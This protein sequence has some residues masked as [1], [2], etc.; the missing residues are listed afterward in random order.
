MEPM[1]A[2]D[3]LR[4][5]PA[6]DDLLR[7]PALLPLWRQLGPAGARRVIAAVLAELRAA[8]TPEKLAALE[9][10]LAAAA[11]RRREPSLRPVI[12]A[13]GV[14]LHTNLGRA[15]LSAAAAARLAEIASSY[16][17]L[18]LDLATGHRARRD[19]HLDALLAELTG[20]EASLV[21]NNNA[22]AVLLALHTLAVDLQ[23]EVL[24]SRGEL[25]EIGESFRIA[26]I[27]ARGGAR[28]VEVGATNRTRLADYQAALT[29]A[30]RL[31]LRVHRSNFVQAG[32]VEQ[33]ELAALA[34]FARQHG[35]P[36]VEDLGSGALAPLPGLSP[37]PT[38]AASLRAG[39]DLV[40]YSGDK[41]LGGPQAGLL[42]GRAPLIARLR[43]NPLFRALRVDKLILAALEAT[44]AAYARGDLDS[45][46]VFA[47]AAAPG[48]EARVRAFA[49]QLP[50]ALGA[51]VVAG[52]SLLGGGS[53]PG[54]TLPTWLIALPPDCAPRLRRAQPPVL[55]RL[56]RDRCLLDLRTVFACQEPA[57]RD[58]LTIEA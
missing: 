57:L 48:L 37:E 24:I 35:L 20:A 30:T 58:A 12:N 54:Q 56:E 41:L 11:H 2:H 15:P 8:P 47:L 25:V 10:T 31:I 53:T 7:R 6:V 55:A 23:G 3:L 28:L 13:T 51:E 4:Q 32:F 18:E 38:V 27:V 16:T 49:A 29:P 36:L 44:L 5:L 22:A 21:V 17:N 19:R 50:P 26:D 45:L 46:P 40:T 9:A 52:E 33:P 14:I 1:P 42:S 39:V 43:A 34:D